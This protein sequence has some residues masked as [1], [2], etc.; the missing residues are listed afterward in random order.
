M[1]GSYLAR[2]TLTSAASLV[3]P[4][5]DVL[6]EVHLPLRIW[7]SDLDV[8]GHMNNGRA[9]TLMDHGRLDHSLRTGLLGAMWRM[10]CR[11]LVGGS[12]V[13]YLKEL[14][15]FDRCTLVTR[16][17]AWDAKWLHYEQRLERAGEPCVRASVRVVC[18]V[19]RR[20]LAPAD[21]LEEVGVHAP[22]PEALATGA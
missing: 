16:V 2:M 5:T 9:L 8:W 20:T 15:A 19:G 22:S 17:A 18:K 6:A 10:R 4:H 14:R 13:Q 21:L 1:L 12:S 3:R 7:T 11:P